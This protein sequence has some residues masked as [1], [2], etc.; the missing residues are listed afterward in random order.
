MNVPRPCRRV[1]KRSLSMTREGLA[2]GA[3]AHA[4]LA[5]QLAF[6][7]DGLAGL[8]RP[9]GDALGHGVAQPK[10]DRPCRE[11]V[12]CHRF[13]PALEHGRPRSAAGCGISRA[14]VSRAV[15]SS[16]SMSRSLARSRDCGRLMG[17]LATW[18]FPPGQEHTRSLSRLRPNH[19]LTIMKRTPI[20]RGFKDFYSLLSYI[21][22]NRSAARLRPRAHAIVI[23]PHSPSALGRAVGAVGAFLQGL[24]VENA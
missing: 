19:L 1:I 20:P 23:A 3:G 21:A 14:L 15:N 24:A 12:W 2:H 6:I 18:H 9:R 7:G 5:R 8:P 22:K 17:R 13:A 16:T 10:V 4:E 11:L